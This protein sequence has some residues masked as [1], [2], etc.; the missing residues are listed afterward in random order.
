MK[1][2]ISLEKRSALHNVL[3]GITICVLTILLS[4]LIAKNQ[5]YTKDQ[6]QIIETQATII[7][8][9][10]AQEG[11][12]IQHIYVDSIQIGSIEKELKA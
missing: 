1:N 9:I 8:S 4:F 5:S 7:H 3:H 6:I 11:A 12:L 10:E 2:L